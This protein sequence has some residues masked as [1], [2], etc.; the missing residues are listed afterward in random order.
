MCVRQRLFRARQCVCKRDSV[1]E[2]E[3][4]CVGGGFSVHTL[5]LTFPPF[6][7]QA[8]PHTV[9][10]C[11]WRVRRGVPVATGTN[12][13]APDPAP[14]AKGFR[15]QGSGFRVQGP[16]FR[17]QGSGFRV[18]AW[19]EARRGGVFVFNLQQP[20]FRRGQSRP[21][22]QSPPPGSTPRVPESVRCRRDTCCQDTRRQSRPRKRRTGRRCERTWRYSTALPLFWP[23]KHAG[24]RRCT[25]RR[26]FRNPEKTLTLPPE[27]RFG[28]ALPVPPPLAPTRFGRC[29]RRCL[30]VVGCRV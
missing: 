11:P 7:A 20:P 14:A 24:P 29:R 16:G 4:R 12:T 25:Q 27:R 2:R 6:L 10:L 17:V 21:T 26:G 30:K 19:E 13:T 22:R 9:P 15:V 5:S 23:P 18:G 3:R 28:G 1:C 8:T